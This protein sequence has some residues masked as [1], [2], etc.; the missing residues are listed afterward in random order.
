VLSLASSG[1][2]VFSVLNVEIFP[3]EKLGQFCSANAF[4]YNTSCMLIALPVG[5]L[6]DYLNN[7]RY[8]YLWS[9]LFRLISAAL[10]LKVY[11]NYK[12]VKG[13]SPVLVAG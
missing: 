10:F 5:I 1:V 13:L 6:F 11:I 12:R 9:A 7:Y 8:C 2:P 3:R 4:V